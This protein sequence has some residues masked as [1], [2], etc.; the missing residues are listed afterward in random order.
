MKETGPSAAQTSA[1]DDH[2][3]LAHTKCL[4]RL[5]LHGVVLQ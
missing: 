4:E 5:D 2:I 3:F 1:D